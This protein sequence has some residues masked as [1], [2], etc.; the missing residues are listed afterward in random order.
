MP[1]RNYVEGRLHMRIVRTLWRIEGLRFYHPPNEALR[2]PRAAMI[3]RAFGSCRAVP[4]LFI[5]GIEGRRLTPIC[6]ELKRPGDKP[7]T[8]Q[9]AWLHA[10]ESMGWRALAIDN[11]ETLLDELQEH[12]YIDTASRNMIWE[13]EAPSDA[14]I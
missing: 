3:M 4:D 5:F 1:K 8:E 13:E 2:T 12:G 6:V 7:S 14:E 9:R 10:L 11:Y